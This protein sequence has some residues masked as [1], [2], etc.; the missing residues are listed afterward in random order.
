[1]NLVS[2]LCD[3]LLMGFPGWLWAQLLVFSVFLIMKRGVND[4]TA[5][6]MVL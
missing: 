3:F 2:K 5:N 4:I 6:M 1:M